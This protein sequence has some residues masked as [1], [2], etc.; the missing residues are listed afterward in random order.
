MRTLL[1]EPHYLGT[2]E[3]F[4]LIKAYDHICLEVHAHYTKQSY[5][6]RAIL[7]S[8]AGPVTLS[9]PVNYTN[10]TPFREVTIDYRQDWVREHWGAL[11]SAYGKAPF[12]EHF[13][14]EFRRIWE[15]RHRYLLDL[16]LEMMSLCLE[17]LQIDRS[18]SLTE[19]FQKK[20]G[21]RFYDARERIHAK[22]SFEDREL[23]LP[24]PYNQIFGSN[25]APNLSIVDLLMCEGNQA[26]E[27]LTR[28]TPKS[29]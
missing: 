15:K 8:A 11:Y 18:V 4:V 28:S 9:I 3:Y 17:I 6:N 14:D 13:S 5:K 1:I 19:K 10:R 26:S 12:F 20:A 27:V 21:H 22:K 2:L 23:Y 16:N 25:F 24:F 29:Q 7:M